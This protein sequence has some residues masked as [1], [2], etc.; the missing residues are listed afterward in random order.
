MPDFQDARGRG[1]SRRFSARNLLEYAVALRLRKLEIGVAFVG[2]V[3]HVIR[4]FE[5]S[6]G[7]ELRDFKLPDSLRTP[8]APDLRVVIADGARLY[9]TL[10]APGS[11]A[12]VY[13]G[14][15]LQDVTSSPVRAASIGASRAGTTFGGVPRREV[16]EDPREVSSCGLNSALPSWRGRSIRTAPDPSPYPVTGRQGRQPLP[17]ADHVRGRRHG[18]G[19]DRPLCAVH[20][21]LG[22][23]DRC[24]MRPAMSNRATSDARGYSDADR[25]RTAG[26][27]C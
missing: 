9:F 21:S 6:V 14:I 8:K 5:R 24:L 26:R 2:A 10:A 7:K 1:S 17:R 18:P 13:G 16:L 23:G 19:D 12:R 22:D 20:E 4:T 11:P 25:G 15:D 27:G 3:V